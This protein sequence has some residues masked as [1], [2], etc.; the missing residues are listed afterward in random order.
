MSSP[1]QPA[2]RLPG[3]HDQHIHLLAAAA[4]L[5]SVQCGPPQV[6]T[7]EQLAA[8][9]RA[10]AMQRPTGSW[11]RG[12][13]YHESVAGEL[14]RDVLDRLSPTNPLRI[15]HR[16]GARWTLNT[17][18]LAHLGQA[19]RD[20]P[21][22]DPITGRLHRADDVVRG[23]PPHT[24]AEALD[25]LAT[26][27]NS[28]GVTA[29]T[30][31]TPFTNA[32]DAALLS[33]LNDR[34]RIT[35]TGGIE[36]LGQPVPP[37]LSLGPVKFV[38]DAH[39]PPPWDELVDRIRAAHAADRAIAVHCVEADTSALTLAALDAAGGA[40]GDRIEH[41]SLIDQAMIAELARRRL[42]VVTQ[43]GFVTERGDQY[44]A[45]IDPAWI[46]DLYRVR[47]LI[48]AGIQVRL[49]TD[50]PYTAANP[51]AA[52]RAAVH[53]RTPSGHVL[54]P[55]ERITPDQALA[56]FTG[57][58]ADW[59]LLDRPWDAARGRLATDGGDISSMVI[60]TVIDGRTVW[61]P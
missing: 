6:T 10:A 37:G 53:R 42:T 41:G 13:G 44:L 47:S 54:S 24:D 22:V 11:L 20:H 26:L 48:D 59:V 51:W 21:G 52:I 30:D 58:G 17:A 49:S 5:D 32:A 29:V 38:L 19:G 40:P 60:A 55:A 33:T 35:I 27:L 45:E 57:R 2:T 8:A 34:L 36:M 18:A 56:A 4:S 43:P 7:I 46:D 9:L 14:D 12:V 50:A 61:Q 1:A 28:Y 15:Q 3:L 39:N 31:T 23:L 25:R 16:S